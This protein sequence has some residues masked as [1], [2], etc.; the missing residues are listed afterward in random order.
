M[1]RKQKPVRVDADGTTYEWTCAAC[2]TENRVLDD[3]HCVQ[4]GKAI[5]D[6]KCL[7]HRAMKGQTGYYGHSIESPKKLTA[8]ARRQ[9][10]YGLNKIGLGYLLPEEKR[11]RKK[12]S[13]NI[14]PAHRAEKRPKR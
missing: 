2:G 1:G 3:Q 11:G 7:R 8:T 10:R 13:K 9:A 14:F 12:G 4:C 6:E 5:T